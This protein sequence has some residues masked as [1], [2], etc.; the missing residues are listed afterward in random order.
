MQ[1]NYYIAIV[2]K[3]NYKNSTPKKIMRQK[4]GIVANTSWNLYNFRLPLIQELNQFYEVCI[5][6]PEDEST[7]Y[8]KTEGYSFIALH[9]LSRKGKNPWQ[10]ILLSRELF[11]ILKRNQ[12]QLVLLYTIKPNIYGSI[13]AYLAQVPCI[14]TVTGLGYSFLNNNIV[15]KLAHFL[16]RVSFR[17]SDMVIFQNQDDKELFLQKKLVQQS[18]A[19]IVR[20]SGIDC[21]RFTISNKVTHSEPFIFLFVG[22]LLHDKGIIEFLEAVRLFELGKCEAWIV[23]DIDRDNPSAISEASL[24]SYENDSRFKFFGHCNDVEKI[25]READVVVLPSYREG[26]PRVMLEA[27]ALA[28]PVIATDVPGC[29]DTVLD[30]INGFLCQVKDSA[31]LYLKMKK[32]MACTDEERRLMGMQGRALAEREFDV[33][34][35]N[36]FY[37]SHI[38]QFLADF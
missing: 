29:R 24:H 10:D 26:L 19:F 23:G 25:M 16:Y 12:I 32:M 37:L 34:V 33:P 17:L 2:S 21:K 28:K 8:W 11:R 13:A 22:R 6:A 30:G 3:Q 4:I 14:C 9:H 36:S 18:K 35:I 7:K 15:S 1:K 31:D 20:G 5:I 38:Q 27:L